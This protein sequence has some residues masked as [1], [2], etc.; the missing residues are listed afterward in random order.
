MELEFL[1]IFSENTEISS[2]MK[3]RPM[4]PHLFQVDRRTGMAWVTVAFAILRTRLNITAFFSHSVFMF[5]CDSHNS[6][7]QP[8]APES[9]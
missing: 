3:T 5:L 7:M 4:G 8:V 6:D 2:F 9:C 1:S